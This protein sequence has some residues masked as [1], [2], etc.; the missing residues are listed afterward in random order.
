MNIIGVMT[1]TE[2]ALERMKKV[3]E[4][5]G[6]KRNK[7]YIFLAIFF[8]LENYTNLLQ[9]PKKGTIINT[10]SMAGIMAGSTDLRW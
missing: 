8:F 1:G 6:G 9:Q 3:S 2:I 5:V 4:N 10:A 7:K